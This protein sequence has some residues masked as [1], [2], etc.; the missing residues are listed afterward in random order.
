M[1]LAGS[2]CD[3]C[4]LVVG[5]EDCVMPT[6]GTGTLGTEADSGAGSACRH[7][8]RCGGAP[9]SSFPPGPIAGKDLG[10]AYSPGGRGAR[11]VFLE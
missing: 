11:D 3:F 6:S 1:V 4:P 9:G 2:R 7:R 10:G 8:S 5:W